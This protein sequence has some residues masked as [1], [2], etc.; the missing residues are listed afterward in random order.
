M[1]IDLRPF[2]PID[3]VI[4]SG[5][6][7]GVHSIFGC[8]VVIGNQL[9]I[10]SEAFSQERNQYL[11]D[12]F[13]ERLKTR[14]NVG[15]LPLG[16]TDVNLFANGLNFVFGQADRQGGA[17]VISLNLLRQESYGLP[18]DDILL[19]QRSVKEAVHEIGHLLGM[20]HCPDGNC[21][22]HFS[23]SLLDTDIKGTHFCR[24]CQPRL[25]L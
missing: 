24:R 10:P 7:E 6:R 23:N 22:M 2:G 1:E 12:I 11:S 25:S 9:P 19:M 16:I 21:V 18:P 8:P 4:L 15:E 20:D 3:S 17:A 5:L 13:I 14:E